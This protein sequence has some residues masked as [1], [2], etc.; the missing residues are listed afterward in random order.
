MGIWAFISGLVSPI[1]D[2]LGKVV[3]KEEDLLRV[4]TEIAKIKNE[5]ASKLLDY[6][7]KLLDAQS[8]IIVSEAQGTSWLQR[9]W[10]PITMMTFLVLVVADAFGLTQ[11]RLAPQAWTLLQIGLG[12]YVIGRSAEKVAPHITRNKPV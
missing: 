9:S 11:F 12:G 2:L 3:T 6:E 8:K 10:R 1:A 5:M 4:E 7:T